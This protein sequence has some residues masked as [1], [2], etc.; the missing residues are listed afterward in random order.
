MEMLITLGLVATFIGLLLL[1][2]LRPARAQPRIRGWFLRGI[3]SFV[4]FFAVS[5]LAPLL[6]SDLLAAHTLIDASGI[7]ISLSI[8]IGLLV[9][10]LATFL[11]HY[12]LHRS[13][14]LWR[15]FHQLHHSA[16]RIDTAGAFYFSPLDM[17][18]FTFVTSLA[19]V[20]VFGLSAEAAMIVNAIATLLAM[21]QHANLRTP[22][23]LGY[24]VQRPEAH[25]LH[26]ARDVHG[27]NYGSL[28]IWDLV[29]GTWRNPE[30]VELPAGLF[31]GSTAMA[32]P[33]LMGRDVAA[34][35]VASLETRTTGRY[36]RYHGSAEIAPTRYTTRV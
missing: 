7:P 28:A 8:V 35:H 22:T 4:A 18:G 31:E 19:L 30:T 13:S 9:A 24:I 21:F 5:T 27:F 10:D 2:T 12:A 26:H 23:W 17:L 1:D 29:F 32:G 16:E 14:L 34:E 11:W 36:H 6:W 3:A 15:W 33:I 20:W 25:N